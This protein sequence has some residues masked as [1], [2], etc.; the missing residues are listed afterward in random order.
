[1]KALASALALGIALL[2]A[3]ALQ[4]APASVPL[5]GFVSPAKPDLFGYYMP[6]Q[7]VRIGKL[8]LIML[9]LGGHDEF[10]QFET[11]KLKIKTYAPFMFQFAD[12]KSEPKSSENG[13]V[14]Y[15]NATRVLPSAYRIAG[16]TIAFSGY[17]KVLGT[18]TF[19]GTIDLAALKAEQG[20]GGGGSG[21]IVI[22]G[23]LVIGSKLFKRLTFTWFGGD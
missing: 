6:K 15:E 12:A 5:K 16:N 7:E 20:I 14:Y 23:D 1:M 13:G 11:G 17:D 4:A 2:A 3:S 10:Q 22:T 19:D 21:K 8:K 9:S 18:V